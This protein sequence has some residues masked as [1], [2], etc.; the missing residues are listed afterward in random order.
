MA[1]RR[2]RLRG[3][4]A[5]TIDAGLETEVV[6][7]VGG[8]LH[9]RNVDLAGD[10]VVRDEMHCHDPVRHVCTIVTS[11]CDVQGASEAEAATASALPLARP[12]AWAVSTADVGTMYVVPRSCVLQLPDAPPQNVPLLYEVV[13]S[14]VDSLDIHGRL[15]P[16]SVWAVDGTMHF[17]D[18]GAHVASFTNVRGMHL[19]IRSC[20]TPRDDTAGAP[21]YA[22][23][24][25]GHVWSR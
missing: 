3:E 13:G 23:R 25:T 14:D 11:V 2:L 21:V 15:S 5:L 12:K 24:I 9:A 22:F 16:T 8:V 18:A 19:H 17:T 1:A 6:A 4:G 10:L 7:R 20:I